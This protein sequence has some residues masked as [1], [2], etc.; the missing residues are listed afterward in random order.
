MQ[1]EG[2]RTPHPHNSTA[3]VASSVFLL[4]AFVNSASL[5]IM[6]HYLPNPIYNLIRRYFGTYRL[7]D[8]RPVQREAPYTYY[9]PSQAHLD[10]LQIG[11]RAQLLFRSLPAGVKYGVERMWVEVTAIEGD[12]ISGK[13]LNKPFDTPQLKEGAD[14]RLQRFHIIDIGT[15]RPLPDEIARQQYW[16]RCM[17][18]QCVLDGVPVYYV[19][20]EEPDL[21]QEGDTYPDSGWRI[22]GD[23]RDITDE[24]LDARKAQ[25]IAL[26]KVL[27]VDD[28]WIH[29]IDSPIG[30]A[31]MR[32]FETGVYDTYDRATSDD[33]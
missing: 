8:P 12:K 31:F 7:D 19:Y 20:R 28:S 21:D 5:A 23:Y 10:S 1:G 32:N 3:R 33:N 22:R 16:D 11:D 18:D 13:L 27:N 14:I 26:G 17:V 2:S 24:E 29:L 9:L 6:L 25:Y 4:D 30:S 15:E